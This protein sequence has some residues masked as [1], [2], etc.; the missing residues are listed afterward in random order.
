MKKKCC[1]NCRSFDPPRLNGFF[2][3]YGP[4]VHYGV[5][6]YST[7][8]TCCYAHKFKENQKRKELK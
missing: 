6:R 8:G 7:D 2:A 1:G 3:N 4:C 5:K